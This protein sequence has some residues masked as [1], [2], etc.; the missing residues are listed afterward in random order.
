MAKKPDSYVIMKL[1][2][3]VSAHTSLDKIED[4]FKKYAPAEAFNYKFAD[5]E[6]AH[7]FDR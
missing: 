7:K 5:V 6:Y 3:T 2:P 4:L 1:S